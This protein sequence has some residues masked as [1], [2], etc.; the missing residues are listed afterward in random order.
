MNTVAAIESLLFVAGNEGLTVTE[1]QNILQETQQNVTQAIAQLKTRYEQQEDSGLTLVSFADKYQIV[2]KGAYVDYVKQ[3]AIS[4]FATKLSQASL[5]TLAIIAY[6][7]PLTRAQ[8]DAIRGVQS[9]GAI[10]KLLLRDLIESKGREESPG[11]PILYGTTD[12]FMNYF[13]LETLAQLP[14]ISEIEQVSPS[15]LEDL[16]GKRY[17]NLT[18]DELVEEQEGEQA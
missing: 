14:D 18:G 6:K 10:Q 17:A 4:P 1:L 9:S 12:Y 7:Q 5:E 11:R 15:E 16:F 2:T 13:G 3:Y 8:I